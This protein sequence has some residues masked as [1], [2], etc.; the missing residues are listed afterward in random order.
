VIPIGVIP[1]V[2]ADTAHG[3]YA[4]TNGVFLAI[5]VVFDLLAAML[6]AFAVWRSREHDHSSKGRLGVAAFLG[7]LLGLIYCGFG[8]LFGGYGPTLR[9]ASVL[10]VL[11]AVFGLITTALVTV[12][13][14][15][16]DRA[17]FGA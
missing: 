9:I 4:H 7:L 6:L 5:T 11:C 17:R 14:V 13:S 2:L 15:I 3:S 1:S 8:A 16:E 12:T 10:L